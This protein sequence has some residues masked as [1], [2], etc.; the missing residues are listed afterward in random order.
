[1]G[2]EPLACD[3]VLVESE[4]LGFHREWPDGLARRKPLQI[5][6]TDLNDEVATRFEMLGNVA[7]AADLLV[8]MLRYRLLPSQFPAPLQDARAG[9]EHIRAVRTAWPS[10][11]D[12]S[13]SSVPA[14]GAS[15]GLLLAGTVLSIEDQVGD[16]PRRTSPFWLTR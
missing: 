16:T 14:P 3:V 15:A 6:N 12:G 13:A 7:E 2:D 5:R 9:L 11:P 4:P 10:S 8:F 1:M